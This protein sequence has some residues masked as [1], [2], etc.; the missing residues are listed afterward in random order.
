M[1]IKAF[2]PYLGEVTKKYTDDDPESWMKPIDPDTSSQTENKAIEDGP[3]PER[4][5]PRKVTKKLES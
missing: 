4:K 3:Q 1:F 5:D 2:S